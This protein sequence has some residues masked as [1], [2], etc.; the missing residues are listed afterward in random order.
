VFV[1]VVVVGKT[2][3]NVVVVVVDVVVG[4]VV[5][6]KVVVD[7]VVDVVECFGVAVLVVFIIVCGRLVA[8]VIGAGVSIKRMSTNLRM[9]LNWT[10]YCFVICIR[11]V[12][13]G[14]GRKRDGEVACTY[15]YKC[16]SRLQNDLSIL[17]I[18]VTQ[19]SIS[20]R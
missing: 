6:V 1:V 15:K 20:T 12:V 13:G 17:L 8:M 19:D 14:G 11:S 16:D 5:D 4:V 3:A 10:I 2:V 9:Y 7:T 18:F